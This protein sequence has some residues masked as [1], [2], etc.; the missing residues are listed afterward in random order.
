VGRQDVKLL[1]NLGGQRQIPAEE[2]LVGVFGLVLLAGF[3][4]IA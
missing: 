3:W 1:Q 2:D 4:E